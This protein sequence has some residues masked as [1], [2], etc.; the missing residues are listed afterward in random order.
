MLK[1]IVCD[2]EQ[3][4]LELME[5]MLGEI[6]SV[7][8]VGAYLSVRKAIERINAGGVDLAFLDIEMPDLSGMEA[9]EAITADPKPL[10]VFATAHPEYAV[11][12]FGIDAIDYI[13]KPIDPH[14]VGKAVEKA[15]RLRRLIAVN[16]AGEN[17]AIE[18]AEIDEPAMLRIKDAGRYYFIPREDVVWIEAAGDYSLLHTSEKEAAVRRAIKLLEDELPGDQFV[19]VHRSAIISRSH[20][21]EIRMLQK[22]EAQILLTGDVKVR[23]SR[24]YKDVI[25][26]LIDER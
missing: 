4:A 12:A 19:R 13:L 5:S 3:P 21:R 20:I 11:E 26:A 23:T 6:D 15:E 1:T 16:E 25:Q 8:I 17:G 7:E 2:D 9:T 22:G 10:I 14:R 24:S 18:A